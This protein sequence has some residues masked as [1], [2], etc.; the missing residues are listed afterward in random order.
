MAPGGFELRF[1]KNEKGLDLKGFCEKMAGIT[2]E[3]ALAYP[4]GLVARTIAGPFFRRRGLRPVPRGAA[5][6][7][8]LSDAAVAADLGQYRYLRLDA[9][10]LGPPRGGR[11]WVVVLILA[12]GGGFA[13]HSPELR[14]L[15]AG[16]ELEPFA[17]QGR[18]D[19]LI[20]VAEEEFFEKKNMTD[21]LRAARRRQA[22]GADPEGAAPFYSAHPFHVFSFDV[23]E[24]Q[25]VPPHRLLPE[26]EAAALLARERLAAKSLPV[27]FASDPPVIWLGGREGQVVEI[28]RPSPT[29]VLAL[30]YRRVEDR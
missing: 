25:S 26:A 10:R 1:L 19:E 8:P 4:P 22:G 7:T 18:L 24:S 15:I 21:V 2:A 27:I 17:R 3:G 16:I 29:A 9:Q 14:R 13:T 11:D 20:L 5:E 12:P 30:Y 6:A 23:L 28:R